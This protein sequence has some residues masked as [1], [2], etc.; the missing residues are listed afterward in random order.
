MSFFF[1]ELFN[2]LCVCVCLVQVFSHVQGHCGPPVE[3]CFVK[4]IDIPEMEYYAKDG[5]GEVRDDHC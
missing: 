3:S 1:I 5:K 4:L 2:Y